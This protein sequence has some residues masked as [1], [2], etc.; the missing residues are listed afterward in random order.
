MNTIEQMLE[1][2]NKKANLFCIFN[3]LPNCPAQLENEI[4]AASMKTIDIFLRSIQLASE[5]IDN[6]YE[7]EWEKQFHLRN[8]IKSMRANFHARHKET[9]P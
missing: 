9:S 7:Q 4:V 1:D 3:S 2:A 8:S 5:R 6:F